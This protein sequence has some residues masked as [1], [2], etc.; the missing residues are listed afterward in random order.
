MSVKLVEC[1]RDAMQGFKHHI[2]TE[3]KIQYLDALL[4]VGFDTIDCGSFVSEKAVPQLADTP[5]VLNSI[6]RE[7][8][9]SKLLVIVANERGAEEACAFENV[10]IIGFPFSISERFQLRNANQDIAGA[11]ERLKA[12]KT[13][14]EKSG[15]EL[16]V[17]LSMGFGN[18][19]NDAWSTD[20]AID[21][22]KKLSA[23]GI[24]NINLSDTIGI[25]NKED[26][27]VIFEAC[28]KDI[29]GV[30]FGAHFHTRPDNYLQNISSA[31]EAGCR[32]FDSA[33]KGF[34]GCPFAEDKLTGNLPTESLISYLN[35]IGESGNIRQEF[36]D[37]A[38]MMAGTVFV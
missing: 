28:L 37:K 35:H 33:I 11:T 23:L 10:D 1:P 32:R 20:I 6:S 19:Y 26:I 18:P 22:C 7:K 8:N 15:K 38:Y 16:L 34:G 5:K 13:I 29:P 36:F 31:Y 4:K 17:Y 21:W 3:I 12:I 27:R 2:P 24:K 30:E 9:G 25:A 14:A